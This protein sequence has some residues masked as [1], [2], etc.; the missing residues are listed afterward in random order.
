ME[1][2]VRILANVVFSHQ[3][4]FNLVFGPHGDSFHLFEFRDQQFIDPAG[5]VARYLV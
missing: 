4:G 1:F 2:S 3:L 5:V